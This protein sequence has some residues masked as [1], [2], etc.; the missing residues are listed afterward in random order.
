MVLCLASVHLFPA[1]DK[2]F[3][4]KN[5][6]LSAGSYGLYVLRGIFC[7][8]KLSLTSS[9]GGKPVSSLADFLD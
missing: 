2:A 3:H 9:R 7:S 1:A 5:E 6:A 4:D 8:S